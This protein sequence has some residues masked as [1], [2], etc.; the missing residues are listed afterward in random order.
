MIFSKNQPITMIMILKTAIMVPKN[1]TPMKSVFS[2]RI[3]KKRFQQSTPKN[4]IFIETYIFSLIDATI[5][6]YYRKKM[7][8]ILFQ[9]FRDA[10]IIWHSTTLFEMNFFYYVILILMVDIK[11]MIYRFRKWILIALTSFQ[12]TKYTM[13]DVKKQKRLEFVFLEH[14]LLC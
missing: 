3:T 2:T 14:H 1:G 4:T 9:C 6:F 8:I 10:I 5:W 11:I 12:K 13:F 7:R